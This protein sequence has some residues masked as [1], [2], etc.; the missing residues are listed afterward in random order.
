VQQREPGRIVIASLRPIR[1]LWLEF[2][3]G[4]ALRDIN[5]LHPDVPEI[6]LARNEAIAG[7]AGS[8]AAVRVK[9]ILRP[10][11]AAIAR[12]TRALWAWC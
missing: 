11:G 5:P 4:W 6:V 12:V 3:L 1:N 2:Y 10:I 7:A 8:P 9:T